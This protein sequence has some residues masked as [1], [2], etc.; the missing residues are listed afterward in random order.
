[1]LKNSKDS[2][3]VI[4]I[5]N[6]ARVEFHAKYLGTLQSNTKAHVWNG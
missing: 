3:E 6:V 2:I 5:V 1:M 4:F